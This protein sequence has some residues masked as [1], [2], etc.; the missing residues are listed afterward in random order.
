METWWMTLIIALGSSS[1]S[2]FATCFFSKKQYDSQVKNQDI[3][4]IDGRTLAVA[5]IEKTATAKRFLI[6]KI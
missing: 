1:A 6:N 4:N 2:S 5:Y 3:T